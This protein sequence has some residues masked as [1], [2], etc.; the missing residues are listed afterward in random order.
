ME[1]V[2]F[3][4]KNS[5]IALNETSSETIVTVKVTSAKIGWIC[6]IKVAH[7]CKVCQIGQISQEAP[8]HVP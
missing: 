8:T 2:I 3:S 7:Y 1:A 4:Y 6:K 5:S